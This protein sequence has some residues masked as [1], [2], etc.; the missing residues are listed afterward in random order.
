MRAGFTL[1][2]VL[3]VLMIMSGIMVVITQVLTA[4]RTSRDTIHNIRETQL[5]GPAILD[6]VEQDLRALY[7]FNTEDSRCLRIADRVVAGLD[8]DRIDFVTTTN[9][10]VPTRSDDGSRFL[11][12][13]VNEVG[14]VLRVNP[15]NNDFLEIYRREAFGVDE[16]PFFGGHYTFLHDRIVAF[17]I[18]V[19]EEDGIDAEELESWGTETDEGTGLP[20]RI[21]IELALELA[22]RLIREQLQVAPIHART[23][24]HRRV[25]RFPESLRESVSSQVVLAVPEITPPV[26]ETG[27]GGLP[28]GTEGEPE[29]E[30]E[31]GGP[32]VPMLEGGGQSEGGG[33][34]VTTI[35]GDG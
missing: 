22:P 1:I 15:E 17:D 29:V 19:F 4:A 16:E 11:R 31:T 28:Q 12:A 26:L 24:V 3:L 33:A 2:E 35:F 10:L 27:A 23:V 30:L 18:K 7:L 13:D 20:T 5:A 6:L 21:E 9:G 34:D 8:A 14:Y 25:I 32:G